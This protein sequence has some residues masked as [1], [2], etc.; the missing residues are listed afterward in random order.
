MDAL[1]SIIGN[2]FKCPTLDFVNNKFE[3]RR[4]L[5]LTVFFKCFWFLENEIAEYLNS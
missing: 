5:F 1:F 3:L 2:K 4:W